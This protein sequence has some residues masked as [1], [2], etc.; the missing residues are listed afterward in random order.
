MLSFTCGTHLSIVLVVF[1]ALG[2]F[3]EC[4]SARLDL[5][6]N[7]DKRGSRFYHEPLFAS[8]QT[9]I[10]ELEKG[11]TDPSLEIQQ[12]T[13]QVFEKVCLAGNLFCRTPS[14][15]ANDSRFRWAVRI[16]RTCWRF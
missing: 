8:L 13:M 4:D 14:H 3:V 16:L 11:L 5:K 10:T 2:S 1:Q 7:R 9:F 12:I 6:V 15:L